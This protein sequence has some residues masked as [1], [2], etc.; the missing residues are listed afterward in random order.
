[1]T[2]IGIGSDNAGASLRHLVA[3][4]LREQGYEI[5]DAGVDDES[6]SYPS[7][8]FEVAEHVAGGRYQRAILICGTGIGVS[9]AANKVPG[10]YA[11]LCHDT[12]S[13][14][15]A[16]KSNSAQVLALGARVV[17]PQLALSIVDAWLASEFE[18]G[19]SAAKVADLAAGE[20]RYA[21]ASE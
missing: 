14:E 18:G 1:M 12:Y 2:L 16:R 10:V 9:I 11:A 21:Q 15:R 13:A 19:P 6:R 4:H 7:V 3:G 5:A 8:A 17:G 20:E